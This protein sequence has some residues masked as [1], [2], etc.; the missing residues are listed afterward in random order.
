M[1]EMLNKLE[2]MLMGLRQMQIG[3]VCAWFP[4][5]KK[6][7]IIKAIQASPK[8]KIEG[9]IVSLKSETER[10]E[11][12]LQKDILKDLVGEE[13][14]DDDLSGYDDDLDLVEAISDVN[15]ND[16][17]IIIDKN[18]VSNMQVES[19]NILVE[20][21]IESSWVDAQNLA[22]EIASVSIEDVVSVEPIV[23]ETVQA[24]LYE[25]IEEKEEEAMNYGEI[26]GSNL[27]YEEILQVIEDYNK[28]I[29]AQ[30]T[31]ASENSYE[32]KVKAVK[33]FYQNKY[34]VKLKEENIL[35]ENA[36]IFA[37]VNRK[38]GVEAAYLLVCETLNDEILNYMLDNYDDEVVY[39]CPIEGSQVEFEVGLNEFY[40]KDTDV[41]FDKYLEHYVITAE[42]DYKIKKLEVIIGNK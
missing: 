32:V 27:T 19:S 34:N 17:F 38:K 1:V 25:E 23:E 42:Q 39:F 35:D 15:I 16:D 28:K 30:L 4:H 14:L 24:P 3:A 7:N 36:S 31:Y 40:L 41:I 18:T 10:Y 2:F 37:L 6:E 9:N 21:V 8:F 12:E 5:E 11:E 22:D 20:D 29:E 26:S 33:T 13:E